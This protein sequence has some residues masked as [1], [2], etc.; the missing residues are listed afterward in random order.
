MRTDDDDGNPKTTIPIVVQA[1]TIPVRTAHPPPTSITSLPPTHRSRSQK[2]AP[3]KGGRSGNRHGS[4]V[5]FM[6]AGKDLLDPSFSPLSM[7]G[8]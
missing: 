6:N 5:R 7:F 1:R 4:M 8:K 3:A 2:S